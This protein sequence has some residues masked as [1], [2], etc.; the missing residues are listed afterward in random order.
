MSEPKKSKF[1]VLKLWGIRVFIFLLSF[2]LALRF[3]L[4]IK[5]ERPPFYIL[6]A[7]FFQSDN[8]LGWKNGIGPHTVML[9][10]DSK[11]FDF[12]TDK[13]GNRLSIPHEHTP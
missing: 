2:E 9:A 8:L 7:H 1:S 6:P 12:D 11:L 5:P 13:K 3:L 4:G 10:C